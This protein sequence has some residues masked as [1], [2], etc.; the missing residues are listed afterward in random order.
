MFRRTGSRVLLSH[1]RLTVIEDDIL[2]KD[3]TPSTYIRF[4]AAGFGITLVCRRPDGKILAQ[5]EYSYPPDAYLMQFPGGGSQDAEDPP[6]AA[7]RELMEE[8]GYRAGRLTLLG[9]FL[10]DNRRSSA[11]MHVY[12]A[13]DLAEQSL[14]GDAGEVVTHTWLDEQE[15]EGLISEGGVTNCFFLAAWTLYRA[16]FPL[17][18]S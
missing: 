4:A 7:N 17:R 10:G 18:P 12:L 2:L 6:A 11:M 8:A 13:E 1:P 14:P 9:S 5:R 16:R 15:I 3:G